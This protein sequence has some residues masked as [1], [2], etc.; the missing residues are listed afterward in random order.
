MEP[1]E[2]FAV[3]PT[4]SGGKPL[5]EVLK[6]LAAE[7]GYDLVPICIGQGAAWKR[8]HQGEIEQREGL[9]YVKKWEEFWKGFCTNSDGTLNLDAIQREL[10]D[11]SMILH[12]VPGVYMHAT[13]GM[14]SYPTTWPSVVR[15]LADDHTN[16]VCEEAIEDAKDHSLDFKSVADDPPPTGKY[17][18]VLR[19]SGYTTTP[20]EVL[21]AQYDPSYKGW[22]DPGNT[23]LTDSGEDPIWWREL[24]EFPA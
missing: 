12:N 16:R 1:K 7:L 10:S 19:R 21:T 9:D 8:E 3:V 17:L 14:V 15:S 18:E 2:Q 22:T 20:F 23:R 11:Y 13:G 6:K 5:L 4:T 24:P